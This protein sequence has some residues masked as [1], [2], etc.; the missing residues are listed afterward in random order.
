MDTVFLALRV[1]VSL[2]AVFGAL[3]FLHRWVTKGKAGKQRAKTIQVVSRQGLGSKAG[4]AIVDAEG[5]RYLVGVTEH[6]VTLLDR[7]DLPD[8]SSPPDR[9]VIKVAT[10]GP[11]PVLRKSFEHELGVAQSEVPSITSAVP[12]VPPIATAEAMP[13]A[14]PATRREARAAEQAAKA[15]VQPPPSSPIAGSILSPTTWKQTAAAL[16]GVK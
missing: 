3:W 12:V 8:V 16:R 14:L 2:G 6:S 7:L 10:T 13:V 4:V 1:V 15:A 9:G 5:R 11:V